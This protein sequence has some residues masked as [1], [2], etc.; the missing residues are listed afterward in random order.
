MLI[1]QLYKEKLKQL[2][3]VDIR[4][5]TTRLK[6]RLLSALPDLRAVS[7]GRGTLLSFEKN[8]GPALM[9]ANNHNGD[10]CEQHRWYERRSLTQVILFMGSGKLP[11][12]RSL[13]GLVN[14][15]FEGA[16]QIILITSCQQSINSTLNILVP[17]DPCSY[18]K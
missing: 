11:A 14:M 15:I 6:N 7:R 13:L 18:M 17:Q 1:A 10:A 16:H 9:M 8:I 5:Y 12:G 3:N 4:V 2:L